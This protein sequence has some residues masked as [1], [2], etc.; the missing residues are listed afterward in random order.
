MR[1]SGAALVRQSAVDAGLAPV[2]P[3]ASQHTLES[4]TRARRQLSFTVALGGDEARARQLEKAAESVRQIL[5][6]LA[7]GFIV[8]ALEELDDSPE[9]VINGVMN[10]DLPHNVANLR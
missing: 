4:L 7:D 2:P 5:P 8:R 1:A 3:N 9:K 10:N 6:D